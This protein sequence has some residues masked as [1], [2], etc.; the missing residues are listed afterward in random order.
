MDVA[1]TIIAMAVAACVSKLELE[2]GNLHLKLAEKEKEKI[3]Y[4]LAGAQRGP[5]IH[6]TLDQCTPVARIG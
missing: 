4:V 5:G 1:C 2:T 6:F 3:I